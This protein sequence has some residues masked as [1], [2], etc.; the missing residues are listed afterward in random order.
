LSENG[1]QATPVKNSAMPNGRTACRALVE[2]L[3]TLA[4]ATT[5]SI[6]GAIVDHRIVDPMVCVDG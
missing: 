1:I 5:A 2:S 4:A 6:I 3:P